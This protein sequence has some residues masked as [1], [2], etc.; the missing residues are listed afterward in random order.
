MRLYFPML[1]L[2]V[3]QS[4]TQ[5]SSCCLASQLQLCPPHSTICHL[6]ESVSRRLA[7][8]PLCPS[9]PSLP[10]VPVWMNVSSLSPLLSD[11]HTVRFSVSSGCFLFLNCSCPCFGFGRRH[12]VSTYASILAGRYIMFLR[13]IHIIEFTYSLFLLTAE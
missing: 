1:E 10:L 9:C 4:V 8:S 13:F 5:C 3:A 6:A 7:V 11:F 12:S 2:W